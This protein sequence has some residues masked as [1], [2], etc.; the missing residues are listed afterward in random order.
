MEYHFTPTFIVRRPLLTVSDD[1]SPATAKK[2]FI[3]SPVIQEAI[4]VAS[5]ELYHELK[6]H[7][8]PDAIRNRK[9]SDALYKYL[10]RMSFRSTPF[11]LFA[12]CG[13]GQ[14]GE[15][16]NEANV[17]TFSRKTR[18]DM[19]YLCDLYSYLMHREEVQ[20][21]VL[22]FPNTSLYPLGDTY[23]YVEY[24]SENDGRRYQ[25][26]EIPTGEELE[27]ILALAK[28]GAGFS[29]LV[30]KLMSLGYDEQESRTFIRD[31]IDAQILVSEFEPRVTEEDNLARIIQAIQAINHTHIRFIHDVL[32]NVQRDVALLDTRINSESDYQHIVQALRQIEAIPVHEKFVLQVDAF[33]D[34]R[35]CVL[36][37]NL[38]PKLLDAVEVLSAIIP[39]RE[40]SALA[41]FKEAFY[42]RYENQ[43]VPLA[44]VLDAEYGL[45]YPIHSSEGF[46]DLTDGLECGANE[47]RSMS[48]MP[49]DDRMVF[50][51]ACIEEAERTKQKEVVLTKEQLAK[52]G[53]FPAIDL[54]PLSMC[55]SV[56]LLSEE[57]VVLNA[58]SGASAVNLLAR[59]GHGHEGIGKIIDEIVQEE[60]RLC[61]DILLAEILHLPEGRLGNVLLHPGYRKYEIPFLTGYEPTEWTLPITDLTLGMRNNMLTLYS[62][63]RKKLVIPRLSNAHNYTLDTLPLYHF[64]C[65]MQTQ[66]SH[67]SLSF[68][69][70]EGI[71]KPTFY[72]R[73][74][75]GDVIISPAMWRVSMESLKEMSAHLDKQHQLEQGGIPPRVVYATGDH[76][77][78][79]DLK[80]RDA[81]KMLVRECKNEKEV[82]LREYIEPA[83]VFQ[84]KEGVFA[85][86]LLLPLIKTTPNRDIQC[87]KKMPPMHVHCGEVQKTFL[88]GSE[89]LYIKLY[90]GKQGLERLLAYE[91]S[92]LL[93]LLEEKN[94]IEKWFFIRYADPDE[95]LRVR[96]KLLDV[97]DIG[98]VMAL[99]HLWA[100]DLKHKKRL[101]KTTIDTYNREVE[102]YGYSTIADIEELFHQDSVA[103]MK[104]LTIVNE[105]HDRLR[106]M[107]A[108][109]SIDRLLADFGFEQADKERFLKRPMQYFKKEFEAGKD[110]LQK[111]NRKFKTHRATIMAYMKDDARSDTVL[112]DRTRQT[113]D[114]IH[115]LCRKYKTEEINKELEVVLADLTHMLVNRIFPFRPRFHEMVIY[116]LL[117]KYYNCLRYYPS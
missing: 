101:Y 94:C 57:K 10:N 50:W 112:S 48:K 24:S 60:E 64:L 40:P 98:E 41:R 11:G 7:A 67:K 9:L 51:Q 65:D 109:K 58:L 39:H 20:Q 114:C 80:N 47:A 49:I 90:G 92:D 1:L 6:K 97:K 84:A 106:W 59:F 21:G 91:L 87:M 103:T 75:V 88:P 77:L 79:V 18:L 28:A 35:S 43:F 22:F 54:L 113:K 66:F 76:T 62:K 13:M 105:E 86:E 81:L 95:H 72:P 16:R 29:V 110:L 107:F 3:T 37:Q 116:E 2:L 31:C 23:R 33:C 34:D 53:L 30:D 52:Q 56:V 99:L 26:T 4:Y 5:P 55:A 17:S 38:Q 108:L 61:G 45:G 27:A 44:E 8:H 71:Y 100:D 89:W 46:S 25:I 15:G 104:Y 73:L 12:G 69:W 96:F 70:P 14:W 68:Q 19:L 115:S 82:L 32:K 102:R 117:N 42:E 85:H 111:I 63:R 93:K 74:S 78:V 83:D 36:P